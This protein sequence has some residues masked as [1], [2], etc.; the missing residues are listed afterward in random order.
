MIQYYKN[1]ESQVSK[2][3]FESPPGG[4]IQ[5]IYSTSNLISLAIRSPGKTNHVYF[6]RGSG[7]EGVWISSSAPKSVLRRKDT[8]LEYLRRHLSS[9]TFLGLELDP[10][11]RIVNLRYQKYG[12]EESFL[13]FWMSR[14]LY[15]IH[16]FH[17][18]PGSP[19]KLLLSWKGRAQ[20][21][22][23]QDLPPLWELF[24]EVGRNSALDHDFEAKEFQDVEEL[25]AHEEKNLAQK[26]EFSRPGFLARKKKKITQ[27]I[28]KN[29]QWRE[30]DQ[31]LKEEGDL[32]GYEVKIGDH[33]I[34]LT[35]DLNQYER[36]NL[37]FE[38]IKK[39]K[40]G[41]TIMKKRLEEVQGEE[42]VPVT[43][44]ESLLPLAKPVWGMEK[45]A[46]SVAQKE[47]TIEEI[48][49]FDHPE[50]AIGLG[51][52]ARGNDQLRS[53]WGKKD[54]YWVHLDGLKSAHA[55]IKMK[56][57]GA[58]DASLL[59]LAANIVAQNSHF[60]GDQIPIIYTQ[61]KNLKGVAGAP[62]MV[63]YKK[64]KHLSCTRMELSS[65]YSSA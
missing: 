36:R 16:Y 1:L 46:A 38:K 33:R 23:P 30:I 48:R 59:A 41:E 13:W 25:L 8:F 64:E 21:I 2:I 51:L 35:S 65:E 39:L 12:Q 53:R 6:G 3:N 37:L 57:A 27:D 54:D 44:T 17:E 34:K 40:R 29:E 15:F 31:Y 19:A 62:G 32:T 4:Q 63:T 56:I 61:V 24:G 5:K 10:S 52:S 22:D 49:V 45:A 55:V 28:Q 18:A 11:D 9:C 7:T 26:Q 50:Y 20:Q 42:Q 60:N 43:K 58:P 47:S 14:K